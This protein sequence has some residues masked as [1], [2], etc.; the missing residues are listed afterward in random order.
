MIRPGAERFIEEMA[1]YY[2]VIVFTAAMQDVT[3]FLTK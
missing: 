2:E 3:Y 1:K